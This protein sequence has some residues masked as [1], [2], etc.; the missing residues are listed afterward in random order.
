M[1]HI[2]T[3]IGI[4]GV[5]TT[6]PMVAFAADLLGFLGT[7]KSAMNA[8]VP[9]F[10]GLALIY[11]I[12]GLA[13]YILISGESGKKEEGRTRMIWGTIAMF[14]LVSVWGLVAFIQTT[15]GVGDKS[16]INAPLLPA[17]R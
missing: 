16:T 12:Y 13:E 2:K 5:I 14:V 17:N 9:I 15:T 10:V 8:L 3:K 11:F 1:K 6:L 4:V 7:V